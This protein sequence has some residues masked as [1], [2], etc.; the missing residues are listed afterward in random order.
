MH[1]NKAVLLILVM[2]LVGSAIAAGSVG[3]KVQA[4]SDDPS[5]LSF[6]AE[7]QHPAKDQIR[8]SSKLNNKIDKAI[9]QAN[10]LLTL[11][12]DPR[13]QSD[14]NSEAYLLDDF[15]RAD[16][17]LGPGWTVRAGECS[18]T[19]GRATCGNYGLATINGAPGDGSSA[20]MDIEVNGTSD[21]YVALVLNFGTG[22]QNLFLKVQQQE[23]SGQFEYLGCNTGNNG[24]EFGPGFRAL[25]SPFASAHMKAIRLGN[26][27]SIEFSNV[28]AGSQPNQR[29][30]C[31]GAPDSTGK[32]IGFGIHNNKPQVDDF[33][34]S[35]D[36]DVVIWEQPVSETSDYAYV[37]E[38]FGDFP[39]LSAY[40]ADD[41]VVD[42]SWLL[43]N[44][45]IPG[46][47][48]D[49]FT[50][51]ANARGLT[52]QIFKDVN[53]F[54]AGDP[55]SDSQDA[56]WTLNLK[57]DDP[58]VTLTMGK[59]NTISSV[60]L[61]LP[62]PL[63][64]PV[65]RYWLVF[66][67]TTDYSTDGMFGLLPSD[68]LNGEV[69]KF[70][71]PSGAWDL[72]EDWQDW[73]VINHGEHDFAFRLTGM[74]NTRW[75]QTSSSP[76]IR[77]DSVLA[78]YDGKIWNITGYSNEARVTMFDPASEAWSIVPKSA[79][80]FGKNYARS[81]CQSGNKVYVF[82]DT[83]TTDF[84]GLWMYD[85][86]LNQWSQPEPGGIAPQAD[87][88]WAPAWVLDDEDG[89]CYL[90]GGSSTPGK[91]DAA[92]VFVY[93]SILNVWEA[94]LASFTRARNFHAA[95]IY[96]RPSDSHKMLCVAGGADSDGHVLSSTQC[97]DFAEARW[98]PENANLG[99]LP[100]P[101]YGMGYTQYPD[102]NSRALWIVAGMGELG[103]VTDQTWFYSVPDGEWLNAGSL[104]SGAFYR[105]GVTAL[106]G[107][108]YHVGG[109]STN[110]FT[111]SALS[112]IYI[113]GESFLPMIL[114][115]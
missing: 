74:R 43:D 31:S 102:E 37:S 45:F 109:S 28:D 3:S 8:G 100:E 54:P 110:G 106:N 59:N 20:E 69:A 80:P 47:G 86:A 84:S 73:D 62:S 77:V 75:I 97:Y 24:S 103:S 114:Q 112:D 113:P 22:G 5:D 51:L 18:I 60:M 9:E 93:N 26:T 19:G 14:I 32:G 34:L 13:S 82:G 7:D 35:A 48:F 27:V 1:R 108:I 67:P 10:M 6:E 71:N 39:A 11:G 33:T 85:L 111:P 72:G 81:G 4:Q 41:F 65:G 21:Q 49:G 107:R 15:E 92:T 58:G 68:T 90:T 83:T 98:K 29:Y 2:I 94:P 101:I 42:E 38:A 53:G 16:G 64:L 89:R 76:A 23:G 66:F 105:I 46:A 61:T 115:W 17:E 40:L 25:I 57:P 52:W 104:R 50:S 30:E 56:M 78:A 70:I 87:G 55:Q 96:L 99:E 36:H 12:T 88:L 79:P 91:A 95:F 44:I 63:E